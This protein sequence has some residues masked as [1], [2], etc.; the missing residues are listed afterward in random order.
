[1]RYRHLPIEVEAIKF[2]S[3][4]QGIEKMKSFC[5]SS[6]GRII[7]KDGKA[8]AEIGILDGSTMI[9]KQIATKGSG[10]SIVQIILLFIQKKFLAK[11]ILGFVKV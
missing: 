11:Y 10:S 6:L 4:P 2:E 8:E 1:M 5:G 3:S 7:K 9:V